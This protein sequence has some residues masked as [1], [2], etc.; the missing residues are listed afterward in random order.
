MWHLRCDV[1]RVMK[2]AASRTVA[3]IATPEA[4]NLLVTNLLVESEWNVGV[5]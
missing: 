2:Y 1:R 3:E 4:T 5:H